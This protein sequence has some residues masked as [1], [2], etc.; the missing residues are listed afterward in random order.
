MEATSLEEAQRAPVGWALARVGPRPAASRGGNGVVQ[1]RRGQHP[2][3]LVLFSRRVG[4]GL[5]QRRGGLSRRTTVPHPAAD[6]GG[7]MLTPSNH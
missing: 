2:T 4:A 5:G 6:T 3:A 1:L 7:A